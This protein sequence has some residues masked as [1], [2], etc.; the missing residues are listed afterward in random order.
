[1]QLFRRE[2]RWLLYST[3]IVVIAAFMLLIMYSTGVLTVFFRQRQYTSTISGYVF[4][5]RD[6]DGLVD[7]DEPGIFNVSVSLQDG[8]GVLL[9]SS[10]TDEEGSYS[11]NVSE[12]GEYLV[13]E[14]DPP[15]WFSVTS[16]EVEVT[17]ESG[18]AQFIFVDFGDRPYN[19]T[20]FGVVFD[21]SDFDGVRDPGE[22][23]V[24]SV[25]VDLSG[26][27]DL[28]A[29]GST[30]ADGV[31]SFTVF[32][33]G[34]YVVVENDLGG[35]E[36]TSDN[37]YYLTIESLTGQSYEAF[38]GDTQESR[39]TI[40]CLAFNDTDGNGLRGTEETGIP[41]VVISLSGSEGLIASITTDSKGVA[42]FTPS[43]VGDYSVREVVQEGWFN[44]TADEFDVS[45]E[46]LF[47]ESHSV[48]FGNT[49]GAYI[50]GYVFFD[51]SAD[52]VKDLGEILLRGVNVSLYREET[53]IAANQTDVDG[54]FSFLVLEPGEYVVNETDPAEYFSTT[55]NLVN[56]S[57]DVLVGQIYNV[58]FGETRFSGPPRPDDADWTYIYGIVFNDEDNS[59]S[60]NTGEPGISGVTVNLYDEGGRKARKTTVSDGG[61]NFRIDEL[62]SYKV[63]AISPAGWSNTT[64]TRVV[65]EVDDLSEMYLVNFGISEELPPDTEPGDIYGF[66]YDDV[67][68]DGFFD[69]GESGIENVNITLYKDGE[70]VASFATGSD[71]SYLFG[72]LQPGEYK[73]VEE[74][75]DGWYNT[76]P[77]RYNVTVLS[78]Q[79]HKVDFGC[80]LGATIKVTVLNGITDSGIKNVEVS[81]WDGT[82]KLAEGTTGTD[83]IHT[84][85]I[86]KTSN[87]TVKDV[88]PYWGTTNSKKVT[89]DVLAGQQIDVT[90]THTPVPPPVKGSIIASVFNDT[91]GDG[92]WDEGE[93]GLENVT[94]TLYSGESKR[95]TGLTDSKGEI[96][97]KSLS[98][99]SY[100]VVE[101]DLSGWYST[102]PNEVEA[103][104]KGGKTT[105]VEFGD[106]EYSSV[107]G[108]AFN[109]TDGDGLMEEGEYG[110][111]G[112]NVTL[113]FDGESLN[114][115]TDEGGYYL[116]GNLSYT[117]SFNI[118]ADIPED[119][120]RTT[121]GTVIDELGTGDAMR[122]DF[123][124]AYC[125]ETYGVV[126]GTVFNDTD[127]DGARSIGEAGLEEV[128]VR[129]YNS[130]ELL[131]AIA[132]DGEGRY[133][134]KLT[135]SGNYTVV[136]EDPPGFVSTTPNNVTVEVLVGNSSLLDFGDFQGTMIMGM[137][138]NDS[139]VDGVKDGGELGLAGANVSC[140]RDSYITSSDG[141]FTLY[142]SG[143]GAF[144][145]TELDPEGY[146][147][148]NAIPG[149]P[150]VT[151]I[152]ANGLSVQIDSPGSII[153]D[154]LF[155]DVNASSVW[156]VSGMVFDDINANGQYD[157]EPG[158]AGAVVDLSSG[159]NQTTGSD[160]LWSLFFLLD[161]S[162]NVTEI[163]PDGFV[164]TNAIPG[165]DSVKLT[166]D[167]I[168]VYANNSYLYFGDTKASDVSLLRGSV[169][170]DENETGVFD[171]SENGIPGVNVTLEIQGLAFNIT[172]QTDVNGSYEF[173]V[174]P[175]SDC[176]LSSSGPSSPWYPTTSEQLF[177]TPPSPGVYPDIDFGYSDD[178]VAVIF[179]V[180]F[181]DYNN[182]G[183]QGFGELG[184]A[185]ANVT[186][187]K[188]GVILGNVT[189]TFNG[190]IGGTF[191]FSVDE[192]GLYYLNE[193]NP[194]G[195]RSTTPDELP[196]YVDTMGSS[197]N[198]KFGDTNR[199]ATISGIVFNDT[200]G[201]GI[202]DDGEPG[203][204]DLTVG[205]YNDVGLV[206]TNTTD[207]EGGFSFTGLV[208]GDYEVNVTDPGGYE[209]TKSPDP[210]EVSLT[211][212]GVVDDLLFGYHVLEAEIS[213]YK[214]VKE[215]EWDINYT[216]HVYVEEG[217]KVYFKI[218]VGN[219]GMAPLDNVTL[220]DTF[221]GEFNLTQTYFKDGN[222][223]QVEYNITALNGPYTN[224]ANASGQVDSTHWVYDEDNASYTGYT[225]KEMITVE[226]QVS[227]T[228]TGPWVKS[229]NVSADTKVY[230]R[231]NVTNIDEEALQLVEVIDS[232][233]GPLTGTAI[234]L[235]P[236]Q[237]KIFTYDV[238]AELGIHDNEV[239][240]MAL[241]LPHGDF[242][243]S[244]ATYNGSEP[245][246][247]I[248]VE[249]KVSK[250]ST[251]PWL[252]Q[253]DVM[254][255]EDLVYF[256][257][258]VINTG[259]VI[260]EN[261]EVEDDV[262]G[263]LTLPK[264]TLL[265]GESTWTVY[266]MG[267]YN[268]PNINTATVEG[269]FDG[270][271]YSDSDTAKYVGSLPDLSEA[272][273]VDKRVSNSSSGPWV[274]HVDLVAG[275]DYV[276]FN[277]TVTNTGEVTLEDVT[278]TD[279]DADPQ[280]DVNKGSLDPGE[281]TKETY[282][283][284]ADKGEFTNTADAIGEWRSTYYDYYDTAADSDTASYTG[285]LSS[286]SISVSKQVSKVSETGPWYEHV[287]VNAG[288]LVYFNVSVTNTGDAE[289]HIITLVD[290]VTGVQDLDI[291]LDP[292]EYWNHT[293]SL[294]A[295]PGHNGNE[296]RV[297]GLWESTLGGPYE[298]FVSEY[299][300]ASYKGVIPEVSIS[301]EK[302]VSDSSTGPWLE[303]VEVIGGEDTVYFNVTVTNE[304]EVSLT[305]IAVTDS[306]N[307][308]LTMPETTLE[309]EESMWLV[310]SVHAKKDS[311]VNEA[312]V[313]S[314]HDST[315][316]SDSDTAEYKGL[317]PEL[318]LSIEKQVSKV[319]ETGPWHEH[320]EVTP[321]ELVYFNVTLIN[322][323]DFNLSDIEVLDSVK[324]AITLPKSWLAPEES[325]TLLY[326]VPALAG[327]NDNE[328][329]VQGTWFSTY[330]DYSIPLKE[331]D[332]AS[333]TGLV[334]GFSLAVEKKV[335]VGPTGPW[336]EH[337][338][339]TV[340]NTVYFNVTVTN[341]GE[342]TLEDL[343][344]IDS[345]ESTIT[346]PV[347]TLLSGE[348]TWQTYS[349]TAQDAPITNTATANASC[350][351]GWCTDSDSASY[352]GSIV[353]EKG[354]VVFIFDTSGSMMWVLEDMQD[355]AIDIMNSVRAAIHDTAFGVGSYV[356]YPGTYSSYGYLGTY[357][358]TGDYPFKMDQDITLDTGDVSDAVYA[359]EQG[360]GEDKPEDH[361][362]I[363]YETL[364]YDW[365]E[366][367]ARIVVLFAD[368]PPH[369]APSGLTL[370]KPW[371]PAEK[372]FS[373][374]WGGDPGLD[375]IMF[376]DDDLD[377]GPMVQMVSD[378][379]ITIICVDCQRYSHQL[380]YIDA[381]NNLKYLAHMTGGKVHPYT[382][383]TVTDDIIDEIS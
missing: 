317:P 102:T 33:P 115:A 295:E 363:L 373:S 357:G 36:S 196:I 91:D 160:G 198:M 137:V 34:S 378:S 307:G 287:E 233:M 301:I 13:S 358:A 14:D 100:V 12:A 44:T 188:S 212:G 177:C 11:F 173:A 275:E 278:I 90:F 7:P 178:P 224:W 187:S 231:V 18:F 73:V 273:K 381:H 195:W 265:P 146:V 225:P 27:G 105:S 50:W 93:P 76:T 16:N 147:S 361:S 285:E 179:G 56:V 80:N 255:G 181:D 190:L 21:D 210:V 145:L 236:G 55:P 3:A 164:S 221:M 132:T 189:T 333:Y 232:E 219:P 32:Q 260:L 248:S 364:G 208:A 54:K 184:L 158:L 242:K 310:Y 180:V 270:D 83:G 19:A 49:L 355:M 136:E 162:V 151:R 318:S 382:S 140:G 22:G 276:Y 324:G 99:G 85:T 314:T 291:Y 101:T 47:G 138:F 166:N 88:D 202:W 109:D 176:K 170:D 114:E 323:C 335:S 290:N 66:V 329:E 41:G 368:S 205:L 103:T 352:T 300:T 15:N 112:V 157:E 379:G 336:V 200:N 334:P 161:T 194:E 353:T 38:F 274:E 120:F 347:T 155:G 130:S 370:M 52:G 354:D 251:G 23:G 345:E 325:T 253:V 308:T 277:V 299:D 244:Q 17:V 362:R 281:S 97:F 316:Y 282:Y 377:Y 182:D 365:R 67:N 43:A 239:E 51:T 30:D 321:G 171:P 217:N 214:Y 279:Y 74:V 108:Y 207:S 222:A 243:T 341:T 326:N 238:M 168:T 111:P 288:D 257:V 191:T 89:I 339:V 78:D 29:S 95:A 272:L 234:D 283:Y 59:E 302:K 20:I 245:A 375:G 206:E 298:K 350:E 303:Y 327:P 320:V 152:D 258:T 122:I 193:T 263:P 69:P 98:T 371:A 72:E 46:L 271:S 192:L 40:R 292:N 262:W 374:A 150:G 175:G 297:D 139:D 311:N 215:Y 312:E 94:V 267:A 309:P 31:F 77:S 337:V 266:H 360:R 131:S 68:G 113:R 203:F 201:D 204:P 37:E 346:M 123:G 183:D 366:G 121:P 133:S 186:F 306:V 185:G 26:D 293:Y 349:V 223:Y 294:E 58:T 2:N 269:E 226:K 64:S 6:G 117:G 148:T 220:S 84:F 254:A 48:E 280:V 376:T 141:N 172:V 127:H 229:L 330:H 237:F 110:I 163:N 153:V 197:H 199:K 39:S 124:Y 332:T 25:Q 344:V 134:F 106:A 154:N 328:A 81:L 289:V 319:S 286:V 247:E 296:V 372:L 57:V 367:A 5:D 169:F 246:P 343:E 9:G 142:V 60:W 167:L 230:Y 369:S 149:H 359:L 209:L 86:L 119:H 252:E 125:N 213:V 143:T 322:T 8:S 305:D 211:A 104:V 71:G 380:V 268:G 135:D 241:Q 235:D 144:N 62:G 128:T 28:V 240:V 118:T 159:M 174:A 249:K 4:H 63:E 218:V 126:Y 348:S 304:G 313:N 70:E 24:P 264:T 342:V 79:M 96:T 1:M 340:G 338:D 87:F 10:T 156:Q 61:Y 116:F 82:E 356:D 129:L 65:V 351:H 250:S 53:L 107:F 261:V 35:W 75:P 331:T 259:N 165:P 216:E 92:V 42:T 227:I 284:P 45:V 256:N 383:G 228:S 315:I